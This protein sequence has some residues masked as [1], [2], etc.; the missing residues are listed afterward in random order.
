[1]REWDKGTGHLSH[2]QT[3]RR[4]RRCA[5]SARAESASG[6]FKRAQ[7][8]ERSGD[9]S[10]PPHKNTQSATIAKMPTTSVT[11]SPAETLVV[12]MRVRLPPA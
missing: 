6:A 9:T 7:D 5:I 4:C 12:V 1:M 8:Y 10:A 3:G 2:Y 11:I